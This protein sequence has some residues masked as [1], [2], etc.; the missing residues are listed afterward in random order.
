MQGS[1]IIALIIGLAGSGGICWMLLLH[2]WK[3][4]QPMKRLIRDAELARQLADSISHEAA[5]LDRTIGSFLGGARSATTS[6]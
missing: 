3:W 6:S 2:Q 4:S 5:Q 1:W